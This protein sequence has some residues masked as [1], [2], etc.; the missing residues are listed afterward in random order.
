MSNYILKF[1]LCNQLIISFVTLIKIAMIS[2]LKRLRYAYTTLSCAFLLASFVLFTSC[3]TSNNP[4]AQKFQIAHPEWS[5]NATIY[6]VNLR[7]YTPSG[8]LNEFKNHIPE[9]KKLG[10]K[11]IWFMP[12]YPIGE[13]NRKGS[14]GSYYAVN[15]YMRLELFKR[16]SKVWRYRLEWL[17]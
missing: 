6:E 7:Q 3:N 17:C 11:I 8:T 10:V 4:P 1:Y 16:S 2:M 13:V 15:D 12:I 5:Y 9:L 14:L